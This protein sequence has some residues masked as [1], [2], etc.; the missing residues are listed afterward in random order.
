MGKNLGTGTYGTT[1]TTT[2]TNYTQPQTSNIDLSQLG[3]RNATSSTIHTTVIPGTTV[4]PGT[5]SVIS[6]GNI[7]TL[8]T[9]TIGGTTGTTTYYRETTTTIKPGYTEVKIV[10]P[11]GTTIRKEI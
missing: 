11:Q 10:T 4:Y 2:Y 9:T 8:G 6:G 5:T 1:S 3:T 7:A